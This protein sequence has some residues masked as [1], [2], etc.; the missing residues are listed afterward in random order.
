LQLQA[1]LKRAK[2]DK[3]PSLVHNESMVLTMALAQMVVNSQTPGD[4]I[5]AG[6][7][8]GGSAIALMHVLDHFSGA[9]AARKMWACDSFQG[10]PERQKQDNQC[11]RTKLV[12]NERCVTHHGRG[13]FSVARATFEGNIRRFGVDIHRLVTVEGWFN[14]T[15]PPAG[16][17]RVAF[18]RLDGDL[19]RSTHDALKAVYPLISWG[20]IIF[21]DDYGAWAG[22]AKAVDDFFEANDL[23]APIRP[24][25]RKGLAKDGLGEGDFES[26][27]WVKQALCCGYA[28]CAWCV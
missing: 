3:L 18:L 13:A 20:G 25:P 27:W 12:R 22:C 6:V 26:V 1:L 19:Y 23:T 9:S 21:V 11:G 15:L 28:S 16:L 2:V 10:L 7:F 4:F 17:K 8:E 24:V 5:E 14:D